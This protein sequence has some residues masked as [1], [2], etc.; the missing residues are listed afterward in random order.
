MGLLLFMGA[1]N[2]KTILTLCLCLILNSVAIA[3]ENTFTV[4]ISGS[5]AVKP[6]ERI[7]LDYLDS[8]C[9]GTSCWRHWAFPA[10][11]PDGYCYYITDIHFSTKHFHQGGDYYASTLILSGIWTL[12]ADDTFSP[13]T[14][15]IIGPTQKITGWIQNNNVIEGNAI[16]LV[17]GYLA[18]LNEAGY[19]QEPTR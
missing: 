13:K 5:A 8:Y 12:W 11:V 3:A 14:P 10:T 18:P 4:Y 9:H 7:P 15:I 16:A 1:S 6:G 2:V 19:C 17:S